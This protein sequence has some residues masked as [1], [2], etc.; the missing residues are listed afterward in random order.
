MSNQTTFT[1]RAIYE[2]NSQV[3]ATMFNG[4]KYRDSQYDLEFLDYIQDELNEIRFEV[5]KAIAK[6]ARLDQIKARLD[7]IK[8]RLDQIKAT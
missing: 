2:A 7:Q 4:T 6:K 8:A 1:F 5:K 3:G